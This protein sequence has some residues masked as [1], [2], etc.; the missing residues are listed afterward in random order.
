MGL[1]GFE[2]KKEREAREAKEYAARMAQE[3]AAE[4]R[5]QQ[6]Q[7]E[8]YKLI[9]SFIENYPICTMMYDANYG[10]ANEKFIDLLKDVSDV[11]AKSYLERG[12]K[13][14]GK[15]SSLE[16]GAV[17]VGTVTRVMSFGAWVHLTENIEGLVHISKLQHQRVENIDEVVHVGDKLWVEI[18][19]I[20]NMGRISLSA[21][22]VGRIEG[23]NPAEYK[24]CAEQVDMCL[25]HYAMEKPFSMDNFNRSVLLNHKIFQGQREAN[26]FI[27]EIYA[28]YQMNGTKIIQ[29]KIN[30]YLHDETS[31][32]DHLGT[33]A[34]ALM[35]MK[36]Y[37]EEKVVLEYMLNNNIPMNAKM[38]KRL[39]A[40]SN[41]GGDAPESADVE[42][43]SDVL[44]FDISALKW[45]D[46]D[47]QG[48]FENLAFQEKTL[49]Y[50]L[51][52]RDKNEMLT[53]GMGLAMPDDAKILKR[54]QA[55]FEEEFGPSA[56]AEHMTCIAVSNGN[57]EDINGILVRTAEC[58]HLGILLCMVPIGKK[59][60]MKFYTLY[61]PISGSLDE[62]KQTVLSL[63][64]ELSPAASMWESSL[65]ETILIAIQQL[66]NDSSTSK[67]SG[68][69]AASSETVEF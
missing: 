14:F 27:A 67:P 32:K 50:S 26:I 24:Q 46:K 68:M 48:F 49:E 11:K 9:T 65:K 54:I 40:L 44:Y 56:Y 20:D 58:D 16:I 12:E 53:R 18:I 33:I 2:S 19:A 61:M 10:R 15:V 30:E 57:R 55:I 5:K 1:F 43:S 37:N 64:S 25:W 52:V 7:N 38:Q 6:K 59:L 63:R 29:Q 34:S 23:L 42:S 39:Q 41:N 22:D 3:R 21:V 28:A 17:F 47:Y 4:Q 45:D 31:N 60:N 66:L 36:A 69:T 51:A 35:W 8:K 13:I 62:Q